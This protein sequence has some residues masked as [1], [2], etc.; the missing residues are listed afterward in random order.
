MITNRPEERLAP[1]FACSTDRGDLEVESRHVPTRAGGSC[2]SPASPDRDAAEALRGTVLW[3]SPWPTATTTTT[4]LWIHE[5]IGAEVVG[6]DGRSYGPVEAVE[7]N[8]ASDLLVLAGGQ[9]VPLV[10]VVSGPTAGRLV[11]DP[12]PGLLD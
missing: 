2:R 5:L 9:L 4:T 7:A 1:G 6:V 8:P 12:P 11:I 10:F 3:P